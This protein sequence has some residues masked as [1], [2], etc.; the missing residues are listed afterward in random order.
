MM[1]A[2]SC[3]GATLIAWDVPTFNNLALVVANIGANAGDRLT[4]RN[5][6]NAAGQVGVS[7]TN[8]SYG[9]VLIGT[10]SGGNGRTS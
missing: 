3:G 8:V 6:G 1:H 4:V 7:G 2:E 10:T 5:Q 9:G